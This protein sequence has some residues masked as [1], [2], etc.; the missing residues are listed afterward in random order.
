M[1]NVDQSGYSQYADLYQEGSDHKINL[2]QKWSQGSAI[3]SQFGNGHSAT[4]TQGGGGN[5]T[6]TTLQEDF[7]GQGSLD[8]TPETQMTPSGY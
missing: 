1:V 3:I 2:T 5:N 6:I 4:Y 8:M 7:A